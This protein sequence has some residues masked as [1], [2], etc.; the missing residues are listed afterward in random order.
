MR[1]V[2]LLA[3]LAWAVPIACIDREPTYPT[4]E[5]SRPAVEA[6]DAS[7]ACGPDRPAYALATELGAGTYGA[8]YR[9]RCG[10]LP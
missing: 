1:P 4:L 5:A 7:G 10:D 6:L 2:L 9:V 8:P 3:L